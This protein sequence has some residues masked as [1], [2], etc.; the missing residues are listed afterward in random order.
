MYWNSGIR[1][2]VYDQVFTESQMLYNPYSPQTNSNTCIIPNSHKSF[3][4][5]VMSPGH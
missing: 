1:A 4:F 5:N 3:L 2:T